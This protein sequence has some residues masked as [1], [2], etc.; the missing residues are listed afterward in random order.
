MNTNTAN[1]SRYWNAEY[2]TFMNNV[3]A[4][5]TEEKANTLLVTAKR[6]A[7]QTQVDAFNQSYIAPSGNPITSELEAL[8]VRRDRAISGLKLLT[9]NYSIN[10]YDESARMAAANLISNILSYGDQIAKQRYQMETGTIEK[11]VQ[12]WEEDLMAEVTTCGL[13]DWLNEL[14]IANNQFNIKY[15]QRAQQIAQDTGIAAGTIRPNIDEAYHQLI[16]SINARAQVAEDEANT[17]LTS[18]Y[19]GVISALNVLIE[20]YNLAAEGRSSNSTETETD[21]IPN[22]PTPTE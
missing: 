20:Q 19:N 2:R 16:A 3:L 6:N 12:D 4:I 10:H 13:T 18:E 11:I 21:P 1:L 15:V 5:V 9:E 7:L 17:T 14:K 22:N 8:D